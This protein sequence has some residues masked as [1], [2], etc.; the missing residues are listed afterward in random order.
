M[1]LIERYGAD[2]RSIPEGADRLRQGAQVLRLQRA[3]ARR[4]EARRVRHRRDLRPLLRA[5]HARAGDR[6][7]ARAR[8]DRRR[9][10]QHLPDDRTGRRRRSRPTARDII[11]QFAA[12]RRR[13]DRR[14][15]AA[16]GRRG[17]RLGAPSASS[18]RR[19]TRR[20][21]IALLA[22]LR[23]QPD[24]RRVSTSPPDRATSPRPSLRLVRARDLDRP[25]G[26]D[27]RGG[28]PPRQSRTPSTA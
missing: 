22:A 5:R 13:D 23:P 24:G 7:A 17:G 14:R 19:S 15:P 12:S 10:V 11:P 4:R 27:G 16:L 26:G 25:F 3:L 1:D 20:S 8:V 18:S 6:E 9:P 28:A 21:P 2:G